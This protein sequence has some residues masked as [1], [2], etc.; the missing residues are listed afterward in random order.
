MK[1]N[2]KVIVRSDIPELDVRND[3][4]VLEGAFALIAIFDENEGVSTMVSG[5]TNLEGIMA[6]MAAC[7][8][9]AKDAIVS[10]GGDPFIA[11]IAIKAAVALAIKEA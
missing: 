2:V 9:V 8:K 1:N 4:S 6:T 5:K 7:S 10:N 3:K 11:D